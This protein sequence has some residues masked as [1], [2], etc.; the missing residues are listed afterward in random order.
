MNFDL[1]TILNSFSLMS[2]WEIIAVLFGIAY[3]ILAAKESL[4]AWFFAFFGTLIYTIIFWEG[5]L[6]SSAILNFYYM[7]MAFYGYFMWRKHEEEND[8]II[9]HS[10]S[11]S[12]HSKV[13]IIGTIITI[14]IG[15][16]M[17]INTQ[18]QLPYLDAFVMVFS[19]ITT[20]MLAHKILENWLYWIV[21][22]SAAVIL[23]WK[24]GYYVTII[25]FI[26]YI[27]LAF[28]GYFKWYKIKNSNLNEI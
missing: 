3:I 13:I 19:V 6:L 27:I 18:T 10:T 8:N 21:I 11:L 12:F 28:Y 17:T 5:Q 9:I 23:Y 14:I 20:W 26:L 1:E 25:L 7:I 15:Y 16:F 24:S 22:D 4:W 2:K